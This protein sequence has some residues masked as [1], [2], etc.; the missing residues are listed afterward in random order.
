ME[1]DAVQVRKIFKGKKKISK[2]KETQKCYAY[3]NIKYI[4]RNYSLKNKV[5]KQHFNI[6]NIWY[7]LEESEE[8]SSP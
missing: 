7:L 1:L 4:A 3:N 6:I 2:K 8:D 5:E